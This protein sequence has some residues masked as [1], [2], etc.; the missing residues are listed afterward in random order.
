ME[1]V[2]KLDAEA[3][4]L[5]D[6]VKSSSTQAKYALLKGQTNFTL[7]DRRVLWP[8]INIQIE[9][10]RFALRTSFDMS[11]LIDV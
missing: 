2:K 9:L 5:A 10:S 1:K 11:Q 8:S 7:N 6:F 3:H 4:S